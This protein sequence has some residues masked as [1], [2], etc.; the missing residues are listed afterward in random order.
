[1]VVC[2]YRKVRSRQNMTKIYAF[3]VRGYGERS[4]S[5]LTVE[6]TSKTAALKEA[7]ALTYHPTFQPVGN[8]FETI[9]EVAA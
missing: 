8:Y 1:M 9:V 6:A 4:A 2:G 7:I 3:V 5:S